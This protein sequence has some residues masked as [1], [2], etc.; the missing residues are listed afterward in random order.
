MYYWDK[1]AQQEAVQYPSIYL[2]G[3]KATKEVRLGEGTLEEK[4]QTVASHYEEQH[5]LHT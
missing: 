5:S 3:E 2:N 1:T 4:N